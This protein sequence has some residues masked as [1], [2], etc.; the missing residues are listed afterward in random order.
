[1]SQATGHDVHRDSLAEEKGRVG[2]GGA[3]GT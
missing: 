3:R 1:V 2:L